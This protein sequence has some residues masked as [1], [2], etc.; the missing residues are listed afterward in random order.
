[1]TTFAFRGSV[2]R[3]EIQRGSATGRLTLT[4]ESA[5]LNWFPRRSV[6]FDRRDVKCVRVRQGR[7]PISSKLFEF[8]LTNGDRASHRFLP[9][10]VKRVL[11]AF[12]TLGWPICE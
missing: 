7:L 9:F 12:Q 11:A 3:L 4:P 6:V 1:M 5:R 2:I 8:V 10:R